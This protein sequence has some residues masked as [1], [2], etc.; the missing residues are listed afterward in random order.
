MNFRIL[1]QD[2]F[3]EETTGILGELIK[4]NVYT[5][6][7]TTNTLNTNTH[8]IL[9]YKNIK[10]PVKFQRHAW[11][12]DCWYIGLKDAEMLFQKK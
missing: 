12:T 4:S 5:V 8:G 6:E 10:V 11:N 2:N 3:S 9:N 7:Q 1:N